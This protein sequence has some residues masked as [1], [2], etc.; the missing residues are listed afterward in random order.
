MNN[1]KIGEWVNCNGKVQ[2]II[3]FINEGS[4][5]K[6]DMVELTDDYVHIDE[7]VK[8]EPKVGEW[9]WFVFDKK[10][11]QYEL[12]QFEEIVY[13]I[14]GKYYTSKQNNKKWFEYCEPFIGNLPTFIK[15]THD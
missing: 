3:E 13:D 5:G 9:C 12:G 15:G 10:K 4:Y 11:K 7:L 2:E 6:I 1:F 8:W 14:D